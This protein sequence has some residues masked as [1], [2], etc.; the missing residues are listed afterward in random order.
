M[1]FKF[2]LEFRN[3]N[4]VINKKMLKIEEKKKLSKV[5]LLHWYE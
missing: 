2:E 5:T 4:I 1:F 3:V